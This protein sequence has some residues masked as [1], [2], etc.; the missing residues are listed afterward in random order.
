MIESDGQRRGVRALCQTRS[1]TGPELIRTLAA[2][3]D[4]ESESVGAGLLPTVAMVT[5]TFQGPG[6]RVNLHT[7]TVTGLAAT[8]RSGHG[9]IMLAAGGDHDARPCTGTLSRPGAELGGPKY[10][11]YRAHCQRQWH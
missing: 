8:A 2:T 1:E 11:Q 5:R 10:W 3:I 7:V 4:S 9:V 6:G